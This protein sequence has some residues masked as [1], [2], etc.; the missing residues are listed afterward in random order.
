VAPSPRGASVF[1]ICGFFKIL[2]ACPGDPDFRLAR[3]FHDSG[4]QGM[5]R[6]S[7]RHLFRVAPPLRAARAGLKPGAG[8]STCLTEVLAQR[9]DPVYCFEFIA[10]PQ[11][12]E[13]K[14]TN[15]SAGLKPG[16]TAPAPVTARRPE[17]PH[18]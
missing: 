4:K 6:P 18:F 17:F 9:E 11:G 7:G 3:Y 2:S 12:G 15:S 1:K 8:F 16:A 14:C 13:G 5:R 10:L